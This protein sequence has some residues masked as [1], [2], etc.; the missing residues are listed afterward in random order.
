MGWR[1]HGVVSKFLQYRRERCTVSRKMSVS[2]ARG[3]VQS[4]AWTME[5]INQGS[6]A[7]LI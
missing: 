4:A 7:L 5:L 3:M 1:T 2:V 6:N